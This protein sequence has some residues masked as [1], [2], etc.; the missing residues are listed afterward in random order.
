MKIRITDL[1]DQYHDESVMLTSSEAQ[2]TEVDNT[3]KETVEIKQSKHRFG[4]KEGLA[5]AAA[6]AVF[7]IG[8][9][10]LSRLLRKGPAQESPVVYETGETTENNAPPVI[11]TDDVHWAEAIIYTFSDEE[12]LSL[13]EFLTS[14]TQ[15][16]NGSRIVLVQSETS[17]GTKGWD[18]EPESLTP[19][20][21]IGVNFQVYDP[22][23]ERLQEDDRMDLLSLTWEDAETLQKRD[24]Y[25]V[26]TANGLATVRILDNGYEL[27]NFRTSP[28]RE[29]TD[30]WTDVEITPELQRTANRFLTLF[31]EQGVTK[32]NPETAED[33]E[34]VSFA[35]LYY[36]INEPG[37]IVYRSLNDESYETLTE[38]QVNGLLQ[39]LMNKTVAVPDG[40]DFT[41]QRGD[42]YAQHEMF[43]DGYFW[44]PAA[45]GDMHS[46]FAICERIRDNGQ[47]SWTLE[48]RVYDFM[49]PMDLSTEQK[50]ALSGL[51]VRQADANDEYILVMCGAAVV[52]LDNGFDFGWYLRSLNASY[53]VEPDPDRPDE[54]LNPEGILSDPEL[55]GSINSLLSR[56]AEQ[57]VAS[58]FELKEDEAAL[59]TFAHNLA[60]LHP[61]AGFPITKQSR[62][63]AEY[64]TMALAHVNGILRQLFGAEVHPE[65]GAEFPSPIYNDNEAKGFLEDGTVWFPV[66]SGYTYP[67]F[68]IC[69]KAERTEYGYEDGDVSVDLACIAVEFN[70]Y[71]TTL[72]DFETG[73]AAEY[74]Q[75][76]AQEAEALAA[77]KVFYLT[78]KGTAYISLVGGGTV[79]DYERTW[80]EPEGWEEAFPQEYPV[81]EFRIEGEGFLQ[82]GEI[83]LYRY[84]QLPE[85]EGYVDILTGIAR[86]ALED[87]SLTFEQDSPHDGYA[88]WFMTTSKGSASVSGSSITG[89]FTY[90]LYPGFDR[91]VEQSKHTVTDRSAMEQAA[92]EFAEQFRG[93][94]G[95]LTLAGTKDDD[96]HYH[97]ERFTGLRDLIVPTVIYYFR[98]EENSKQTVLAQDGL[99]VPVACGDST[100]DD[101]T[102]HVFAVTVWPD[103]TVVRGDNYI[104]R[105]KVISDGTMETPDET[106]MN[107]ILSFMTSYAENDVF[108]LES[109]GIEEYV[110][111]FWYGTVDPILTVNYHFASDPAEHFST[112]IVIPGLL[113]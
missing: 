53:V 45:D 83:N 85:A 102:N 48:Y 10:G 99:E 69:T 98:S 63:G 95:E 84:E 87:D 58:L 6:A 109:A 100:I 78:E 80:V 25:P 72:E 73:K 40:T 79:L 89:R 60:K 96:L 47:G 14:H 81:T 12:R 75:L 41:Q 55:R 46:Q 31:A 64:D 27:V 29:Q 105:A 4:W 34:L 113:D 112:Q 13:N 44:F 5:V 42:N 88:N 101:L 17:L 35:H 68:A 19:G 91:V 32:L 107:A 9:F 82:S 1:L 59:M 39:R 77:Q 90:S 103:G 62:N 111:Y 104:T 92:R 30:P 66:G 7:V 94:T 49:G 61:D 71:E 2:Q 24:G 8:G 21:E 18:P 52:Q 20:M 106:A 36:K 23:I 70:V 38:E 86:K 22:G 108:V 54:P 33:Y 74:C 43:R 50:D 76:T 110:V 37:A 26:H 28:V 15:E 93:I 3:M 51:T 65:A 11:D 57:D 97:D 56:L 67:C 16:D